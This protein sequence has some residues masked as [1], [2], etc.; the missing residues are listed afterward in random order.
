MFSHFKYPP[1]KNVLHY[2]N[3]I[4]WGIVKPRMSRGALLTRDAVLSTKLPVPSS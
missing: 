3:I 4:F 2:L 1:I